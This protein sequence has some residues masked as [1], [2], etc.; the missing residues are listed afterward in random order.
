LAIWDARDDVTFGTPAV[1]AAPDFLPPPP[2]L[3]P[4]MNRR[5]RPDHA[6][7]DGIAAVVG[8]GKE[9][10]F[11]LDVRGQEEQAH[12]LRHAR[13]GDVG[14]AGEVDVVGDFAKVDEFLHRGSLREERLGV[15][16]VPG[17]CRPTSPSL[18]FLEH[19][20]KLL[21]GEIRVA[22]VRHLLG[23]QALQFGQELGTAM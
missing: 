16:L 20:F 17:G 11:C 2:L 23:G 5:D 6:F 9:E 15:N 21:R 22:E 18:L 7:A 14:E 3:P 4:I 12:D 13:G 1:L 19:R 10:E 8:E